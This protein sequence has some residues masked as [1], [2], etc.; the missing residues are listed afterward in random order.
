MSQNEFMKL[1]INNTAMRV[2]S[3]YMMYGF[4][5]EVYIIA[6]VENRLTCSK[7]FKKQAKCI[8]NWVYIKKEKRQV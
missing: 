3:V 5:N 1:Y 6:V 4:K 7:R 2:D 8:D